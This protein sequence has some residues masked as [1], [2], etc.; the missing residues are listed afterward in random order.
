[1]AGANLSSLQN[2]CRDTYN[3][4]HIYSTCKDTVKGFVY[5]TTTTEKVDIVVN[6]ILNA[7]IYKI[8]LTY[9]S[10]LSIGLVLAVSVLL[11]ILPLNKN[12]YY[13]PSTENMFNSITKNLIADIALFTITMISKTYCATAFTPL[14]AILIDSGKTLITMTSSLAIK[15]YNRLQKGQVGP[16][17]DLSKLLQKEA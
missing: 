17:K 6:G 8:M 4:S 13:D 1:M 9:L 10:P 5:N 7:A 3:N 16:P 12:H 2:Y 15:G 14:N 11:L